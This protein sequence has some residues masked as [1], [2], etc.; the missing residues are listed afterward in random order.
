MY[1]CNNKT[2]AYYRIAYKQRMYIAVKALGRHVFHDARGKGVQFVM[3]VASIYLEQMP[4]TLD[5]PNVKVI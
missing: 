5:S 3:F 4:N 1:C 2:I